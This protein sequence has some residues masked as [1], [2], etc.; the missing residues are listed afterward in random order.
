LRLLVAGRLVRKLCSACKVGYTPDPGQLRKL[1]MN[2]EEVGKLY[3]ARKEPMRDSKGHVVPCSFC[4]DLGFKGRIGVYEILKVDDEVR[5][6]IKAGGSDTQL[7]QAFRK[8]RG[9]LIQEMALAQV[10]AG[11]TSVEEVLRIFK[12]DSGSSASGSSRARQRPSSKPQAQDPE[13]EAEL[14]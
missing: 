12:S 3:A 13:P 7:K 10:K 9:R 4:Q 11:E 5:Q 1:N 14:D 6:V 8:Q 2:P